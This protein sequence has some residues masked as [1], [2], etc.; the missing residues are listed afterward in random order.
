M[1]LIEIFGPEAIE[2]RKFLQISILQP[3][4]IKKGG[5]P[6]GETPL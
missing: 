1:L 5:P 2:M 4:K 6:A 3:H